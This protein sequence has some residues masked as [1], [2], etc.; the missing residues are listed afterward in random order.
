MRIKFIILLILIT[1]H[2]VS[3]SSG[4]MGKRLVAGYGFY[5]SPYLFGPDDELSLNTLHEGFVDYAFWKSV[6]F[7]A[8]IRYYHSISP[9][10]CHANGALSTTLDYT[11]KDYQIPTGE[12]DIYGLNYCLYFK[13]FQSGY[14]APWGRYFIFGPTLYTYSATYDPNQMYI[15][16]ESKNYSGNVVGRRKISDFGPTR[17][18]FIRGDLMIGFGRCRVISDRITLDYGCNANLLAITAT[19]FDVAP[20]NGLEFVSPANIPIG[21]YVERTAASRVRGT[22]RFNVF[23]KL[24]VLF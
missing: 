19:I 15:Y 14:S 18:S 9:N 22:S 7:G 12:I 3:Q 16:E 6:S 4:Y 5:A 1:N 21:S 8:S 13:I 23:L 20:G 24:G 2:I 11:V 10:R 17:Q